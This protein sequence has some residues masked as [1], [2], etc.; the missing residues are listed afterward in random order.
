L[1]EDRHKRLSA[2]PT[3]SETVEDLTALCTFEKMLFLHQVALF[4]DLSPDDLY[5]LS[6]LAREITVEAPAIVV[7][8]GDL[9]DD[10]YVITAGQTEASVKR[11]GKERVI[12]TAGA[13]SVIGE[14]AVIDGHPRSAT[15]RA[16]TPKVQLLLISGM[17]FRH[18][19][20]NRSD[21]SAQIMRMITQRL[22]QVL[23]SL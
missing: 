19:L 21:L 9:G 15:V 8:E 3:S 16:S 1:I 14:M 2:E 13:G 18:V 20:A 11:N 5:E 7:Q 23:D 4:A 6:K 17:D 10:L 12:G 22:R